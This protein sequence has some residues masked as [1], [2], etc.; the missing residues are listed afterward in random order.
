M[1]DNKVVLVVDD[2]DDAI[3]IA[4]EMLSDVDLILLA[5]QMPGKNGFDVFSALKANDATSG[6]PVVMLTAVRDK[7]GVGFSSDEMGDFLG[8]KPEVFLEK[9]VK[10]DELQ[11]V[12]KE[13]L[14]L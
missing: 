5:V 13:Q 4:K 10:F 9:P 7:V 6:I 3:E 14:S 2:E 1:S 8:A 11:A 12:V